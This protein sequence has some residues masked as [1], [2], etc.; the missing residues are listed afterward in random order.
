MTVNGLDVLVT[1]RAKDVLEFSKC[2]I[3][4]EILKM[5][6]CSKSNAVTGSKSR[7][8]RV[9]IVAYQRGTKWTFNKGYSIIITTLW[10]V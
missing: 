2:L 3:K 6:V 4:L 5:M 8:G 1:T 10:D 9:T 7:K